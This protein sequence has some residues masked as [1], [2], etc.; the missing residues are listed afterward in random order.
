[1]RGTRLSGKPTRSRICCAWLPTTTACACRGRARSPTP[2]LHAL[3]GGPHATTTPRANKLQPGCSNV[4]R[5][6]DDATSALRAWSSYSPTIPIPRCNG[7]SA[8]TA[9]VSAARLRS[10]PFTRAR[11]ALALKTPQAEPGGGLNRHRPQ[12]ERER[13]TGQVGTRGKHEP[14]AGQTVGH[15][16]SH[17]AQRRFVSL[18]VG[19]DLRERTRRIIAG[20]EVGIRESLGQDEHVGTAGFRGERCNRAFELR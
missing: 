3:S 17:E 12:S 13:P 7:R 9:L 16:G 18:T 2:I 4:C 1:M 5:P 6:S 15:S 20:R 11:S 10:R 19:H 8:R 14:I